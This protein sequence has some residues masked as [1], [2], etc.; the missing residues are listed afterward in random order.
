MMEQRMS[1]MM[2]ML[3]KIEGIYAETVIMHT[4]G[5]GDYWVSFVIDHQLRAE[6]TNILADGGMR[7]STQIYKQG[8]YDNKFKYLVEIVPI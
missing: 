2:N 8:S 6:E 4:G 3:K 1:A 7:I 5:L